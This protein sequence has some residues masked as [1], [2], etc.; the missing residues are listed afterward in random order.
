MFIIYNGVYVC[1]CDYIYIVSFFT[2]HSAFL[3]VAI[4]FLVSVCS[5]SRYD[6]F[7][8]FLYHF[9]V[10][11]VGVV[12]FTVACLFVAV[13]TVSAVD[14]VY[15]SMVL[16]SASKAE[17]RHSS[18]FFPYW[19][20]VCPFWCTFCPFYLCCAR[21]WLSFILNREYRSLLL[22]GSLCLALS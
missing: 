21:Q 19:H 5:V 17:R 14:T 22:C 16:L 13:R 2:R 11:S 3:F 12:Y 1:N 8:S 15:R 18:I 9:S 6:V 4:R 10:H 20:S 7:S